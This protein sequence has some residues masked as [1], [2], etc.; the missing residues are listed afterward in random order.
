[1][2][3]AQTIMGAS[4]LLTLQ[5]ADVNPANW[6]FWVELGLGDPDDNSTVTPSPFQTSLYRPIVAIEPYIVGYLDE[7][8]YDLNHV[9]LSTDVDSGGDFTPTD[10]LLIVAQFPG[11]LLRDAK[12]SGA[13]I[14]EMAVWIDGDKDL[15]TGTLLTII[16]HN[17][18]WW[19][20]EAHYRRE[21]IMILPPIV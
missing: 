19:D 5:A 8:M 2:E 1:M 15:K 4:E 6:K 21:I 9:Q 10:Y 18:I 13:Y 12:L 17:R 16:N 3:Y 14:R 7:D 20:A 11:K